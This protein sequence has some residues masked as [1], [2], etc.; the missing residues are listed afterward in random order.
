MNEF[1]KNKNLSLVASNYNIIDS[2]SKI[3]K[4]IIV[5][6]DLYKY[7]K[8]LIFTNSIAHSTVMYRRKILKFI[9]NY[10]QNFVYAQDYALYLKIITRFKIKIIKNN[11][12]NLRINHKNSETYRLRN[13]IS[14]RVE[15]LKLAL[16]ALYNIRT[17]LFEKLKI[18]FKILIIFV[19]LFKSILPN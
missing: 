15:E 6:D 4:K 11:L 13:S 10:P 1:K 14:I 16:W 2:K 17:N 9:G 12:A 5:K 18:F 3:V 7:P 8:K 19:K